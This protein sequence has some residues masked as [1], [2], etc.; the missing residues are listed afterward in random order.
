MT[1]LWRDTVDI[2]P[3]TMDLTDTMGPP[4]GLSPRAPV[5]ARPLSTVRRQ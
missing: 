5:T 2:P 1:D 4:V 3:D